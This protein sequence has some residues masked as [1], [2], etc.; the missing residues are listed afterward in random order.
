MCSWLRLC[1]TTSSSWDVRHISDVNTIGGR[2]F[3]PSLG[4][5]WRLC[6]SQANTTTDTQGHA[7]PTIFAQVRFPARVT[8]AY[9]LT[10]N[11]GSYTLYIC[12]VCIIHIRQGIPRRLMVDRR[13]TMNDGPR[14]TAG[15]AEDE[16]QSVGRMRSLCRLDRCLR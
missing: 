6:P 11:H 9:V 1:P 3:S 13:E 7:V 12:G 4:V 14:R 5:S 15:I 16:K 2:Y 10:Y 8:W